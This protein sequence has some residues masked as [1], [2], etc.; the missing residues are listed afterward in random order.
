MDDE[1]MESNPPAKPDRTLLAILI[2]VG[3]LV[4]VA[5][6]VVLV[7][8]T[9]RESFAPT[10]PEGVVQRYAQAVI[11]GDDET[12]G[13]YLVEPS[14]EC[15]YYDPGERNL[16]LTFRSTDTSPTEATVRVTV[17]TSYSGGLFSDYEYSNDDQFRLVKSGDSWLIRD[18]PYEFISC[19]GTGN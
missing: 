5:L 6:V 7:R 17:T 15:D 12:A 2:A 11:D 16:R 14:D 18:T 19:S 13:Q 9:A 10:T 4:V 8:G 1:V 3:L